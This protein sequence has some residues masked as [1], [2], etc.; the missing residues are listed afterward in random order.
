MKATPIR[1]DTVVGIDFQG[2]TGAASV[3][4][5]GGTPDAPMLASIGDKMPVIDADPGQSRSWTQKA[6]RVLG[7]LDDLLSRNSGKFDAVISGLERL[8]GGG[9]K[10]T[11]QVYDLAAATDFA[12]LGHPISWQLVIAEPTVLLTLNTDKVL[13]QISETTWQPFGDAKWTDN[14]P[15]LFQAKTIQSFEN[16]G[17]I[18]SVLRPADALD[19]DYRLLIDLRL[20]HF[21]TYGAPEAVIDFV[22]KITDRDGAV[23]A[24]RHF[25]ETHASP[26]G[27]QADALATFSTLFSS[28]M[29]KLVTWTAAALPG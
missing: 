20:F 18:D 7:G 5:T 11:A 4:M 9:D 15:N 26:S 6:G 8:A 24:S 21:A 16:A 13:Q 23:I 17:F 28:S 1:T 12:P 27:S 29:N 22:V 2:L 10:A 19:P 14:L 25:R 3:L